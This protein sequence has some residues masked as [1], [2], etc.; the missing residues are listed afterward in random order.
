MCVS[1]RSGFSGESSAPFSPA[2]VNDDDDDV[3][4]AARA[5]HNS[6]KVFTKEENVEKKRKKPVCGG[7]SLGR[8]V[9]ADGE[10]VTSGGGG[11]GGGAPMPRTS[12]YVKPPSAE[13]TNTLKKNGR[14]TGKGTTTPTV[15][16]GSCRRLHEH[17]CGI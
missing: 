14:R 8:A 1:S 5:A 4:N 3:A 10:E 11:G 17:V 6:E 13:R 9:S 16:T 15:T 2:A 12:P 7:G